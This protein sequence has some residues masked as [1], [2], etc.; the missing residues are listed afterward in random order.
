[1]MNKLFNGKDPKEEE[2]KKLIELGFER[3]KVIKALKENNF[4]A[5]QAADVLFKSSP[6]KP[7]I[8][9]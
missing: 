3:E 8:Y 2:I 4:N 6:G 5:T 9:K 7:Q 1:M